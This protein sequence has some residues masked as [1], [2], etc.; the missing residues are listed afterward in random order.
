MHILLASAALAMIQPA[1][2]A[3]RSAVG[4]TAWLFSTVGQSEWCPP[5]HVTLDLRTG[6]YSFVARAARTVCNDY[7]LERPI[8]KGRLKGKKLQAV[9]AAY[10]RALNERLVSQACY[11]DKRP[12]RVIVSNGGTP[13]LVLVN[14]A[15]ARSAPDDLSCWSNSAE[16]LHEILDELFPSERL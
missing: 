6:S 16:N 4:R 9:R 10:V 5:G 2:L 3:D 14:G 11:Y 15:F 7:Q 12:D 13:T 1:S 8:A